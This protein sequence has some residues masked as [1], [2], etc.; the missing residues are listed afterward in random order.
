M[1]RVCLLVL[2][3]GLVAVPAAHAAGQMP[4]A[5]QDGTGLLSADGSVRYLTLGARPNTVVAEVRT[6]DG[7]PI[8]ETS[9]VGTY[10]IPMITYNLAAGLSRDGTTLVVGGTTLT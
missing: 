7:A 2:A 1:R 8:R 3:L 4:F 10:G 9:L 6:K 5:L